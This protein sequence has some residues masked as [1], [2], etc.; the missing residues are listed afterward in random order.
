M[1][2]HGEILQIFN[3]FENNLA[4]NRII[5]SNEINMLPYSFMIRYLDLDFGNN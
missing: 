5:A 4:Y 2:H 1:Y 3:S